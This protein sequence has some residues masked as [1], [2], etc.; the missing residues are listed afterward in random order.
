MYSH[1]KLMYVKI[2]IDKK[3]YILLEVLGPF[4]HGAL[5]PCDPGKG[6]HNLL[7]HLHVYDACIHESCTHNA[8]T[9]DA[10]THNACMHDAYNMHDACNMHDAFTHEICALGACAHDGCTHDACMHVAQCTH[11]LH[12]HFW[13]MLSLCMH[14]W[15]IIWDQGLYLEHDGAVVVVGLGQAYEV[16]IVIPQIDMSPWLKC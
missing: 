15:Y 11:M 8:W 9:H 13:C 10:C 5:R 6:D 14:V 4:V 3:I 1:I 2:N 12:I 16:G 7:F